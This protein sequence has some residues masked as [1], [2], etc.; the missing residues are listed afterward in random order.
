MNRFSNTWSLMKSS[1]RVLKKEKKLLIFPLLSGLAMLIIAVSFFIPL[2][3]GG[4]LRTLAAFENIPIVFVITII[5]AFYYINYFF[6]LFFNAS[7][8][9]AAIHVM[10]GGRPSIKES[11][12]FVLQRFSALAGWTLIA[13]TVGLII[14]SIENQSDRFGFIMT[15]LLGLS[16]T[17]TSF[18]VLPVLVIENKGPITSLK[19]SASMLRESWGEQLIG[20]FSFGLIFTVLSFGIVGLIFLSTLGGPILTAVGF[21]IGIATI[22][23]LSLLQWVFQSIFMGTIYVYVREDQL[24]ADFSVSQI[25]SAMR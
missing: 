17:V 12:N 24:P 11:M 10:K 15:G 1:F 7:A 18:L 21:T 25:N 8:V 16:W 19:E 4:G 9:I 14:N 23:V 22:A 20:H 5:F 2:F 6:V 3:F 13:A